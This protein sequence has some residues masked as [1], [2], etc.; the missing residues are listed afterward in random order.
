MVKL[1]LGGDFKLGKK[2][3]SFH[4]HIF[5]EE[6]LIGYLATTDI[7]HLNI[8]QSHTQLGSITLARL[9]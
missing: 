5:P 9:H 3:K 7:N 1:F 2:I 8:S 4:V 6:N